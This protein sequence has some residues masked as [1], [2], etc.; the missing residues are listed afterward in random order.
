M[1]DI[2]PY[3]SLTVFIL[4]TIV[5][6]IIFWPNSGLWLRYK[7]MAR[8]SKRVLIEDALKH[9]YDYE[10]NNLNATINS[11]AG[12]LEVS[13]DKSSKIVEN[14]RRLKLVKLNDQ[15]LSLTSDGRSYALRVIRVHRLWENYLA[16]ETG[17]KEID[18]HEEAEKVE[19]ILS[20]EEADKLSAKMG[21]PK[22][23]PHG[24]PIPTND[25]TVFENRGR[26]LNTIETGEVAKII[27][28]EDEPKAIYEELI[29]QGLYPGKEVFI[30]N[31]SDENISI[32]SDGE[33]STLTPLVA[34]KVTVDV[35][36]GKEFINKKIRTLIDLALGETAKVL[37]V[38]PN[39]RGQQRR[40]LL[41]FGI[42]PGATISIHMKGPLNDPIAYNVKDTLV[43][44]RKDQAKK[45]L[46]KT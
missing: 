24:D 1:W 6:L 9:L 40:R 34:S 26:L 5:F 17:I 23:D 14:L 29:S 28:I 32:T 10:S 25:G 38:S 12:N 37:N 4:I 42:V 7:R 16:E 11:I 18:W 43:A 36:A 20:Q 46:I 3:L 44:L 41:D 27:H 35:M 30:N 8:T 22:F 2:N 39:C 15:F 21:N 19:H 45:I 13:A 31:K 33:N